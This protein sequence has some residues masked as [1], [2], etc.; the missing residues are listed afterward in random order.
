MFYYIFLKNV[1]NPEYSLLGG[2]VETQKGYCHFWKNASNIFEGNVEKEE[3]YHPYLLFYGCE[4]GMPLNMT[5]Y[6]PTAKELNKYDQNV[7]LIFIYI[8]YISILV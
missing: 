7:N 6:T 5:G 8:V 2:V 4:K 1:D 3:A